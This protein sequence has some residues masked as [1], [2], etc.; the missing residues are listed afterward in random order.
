ME[1]AHEKTGYGRCFEISNASCLPKNGLDS[2][3]PVQTASAVDV[4][5]LNILYELYS[6]ESI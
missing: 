1:E 2:A 3:D 5:I 6:S 4:I